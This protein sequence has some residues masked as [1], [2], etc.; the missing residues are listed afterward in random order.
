MDQVLDEAFAGAALVFRLN[1][2]HHLGQQQ[3]SIVVSHEADKPAGDRREI[4]CDD[5]NDEH[6]R[7]TAAFVEVGRSERIEYDA[8]HDDD[9]DKE[10]HD[11]VIISSAHR[12]PQSGISCGQK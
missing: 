6:E 8:R 9:D 10:R 7:T 1:D 11:V 2:G 12:S 5:R 4:Q 3:Q